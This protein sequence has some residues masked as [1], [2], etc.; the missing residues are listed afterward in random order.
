V[1][2]GD[3]VLDVGGHIGTFSI[4][5]AL[6][7]RARRIITFEPH[8][9]NFRM[10]QLNVHNN[11]LEDTITVVNI[12]MSGTAGRARFAI[13]PDNSGAHRID[14]EGTMEVQCV[15]LPQVFADYG[16]EKVDYLKMDCE[17]SEYDIFFS[18]PDDLLRRI[19][20]ISM[21][22]HYSQQYGGEKKATYDLAKYLSDRGF[23]TQVYP[24]G[25][26]L[27]AVRDSSDVSTCVEG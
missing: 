3:V 18:V 9:D 20:K 21:E 19:G 2:A 25:W 23:A 27:Y 12:A 15:T 22:C 5:A 11:R 10:L 7:R 17:G 4:Y 13:S 14:A 8:P 16:L 1:Q 26:R 24:V 6:E